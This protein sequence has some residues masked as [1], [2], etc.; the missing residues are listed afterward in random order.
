MKPFA[1]AQAALVGPAA[2]L[3]LLQYHLLILPDLLTCDILCCGDGW[4]PHRCPPN[5]PR[6]LACLQSSVCHTAAQ[7]APARPRA[8]VKE[9]LA[10]LAQQ[11]AWNAPAPANEFGLP[12]FSA[13]PGACCCHTQVF[14]QA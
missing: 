13:Y 2:L 9:Q 14:C 4:Q 12:S 1:Q 10:G 11:P 7:T 3:T 8:Q 5:A 6:A